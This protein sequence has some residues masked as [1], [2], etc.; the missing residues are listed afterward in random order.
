[1]LLV[2][3][4]G[5]FFIL[6]SMKRAKEE[7]GKEQVPKGPE[8]PA[9]SAAPSAVDGQMLALGLSSPA[10]TGTLPPAGGS[11]MKA[12]LDQGAES[13]PVISG[14]LPPASI[15]LMVQSDREVYIRPQATPHRPVVDSG[16]M[17]A[18]LVGST[19]MPPPGFVRTGQA[20]LA[21]VPDMQDDMMKVG[22][23]E[24]PPQVEETVFHDS[25]DHV[26]TPAM[27]E[28]RAATESKGA[29]D[30]LR[31]LNE[32]KEKGALSEE[33]FDVSKRRLLRKI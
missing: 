30:L 27:A 20:N 22:L 28:S 12:P 23:S 13:E 9:L 29:V 11:M 8:L 24:G 2:F 17:S 3:G 18:P 7:E 16:M 26:W 33:E 31:E 19:T 1:L 15:D 4:I 32:L 21:P 5:T 10:M 14:E 6:R 25:E